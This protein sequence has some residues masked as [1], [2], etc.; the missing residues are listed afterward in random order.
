MN[1]DPLPA[2]LPA[3]A[4][5][6]DTRR[7]PKAHDVQRTVANAA[8]TWMAR[9]TSRK[10]KR[11]RSEGEEDL[12]DIHGILTIFVFQY[13][14]DD[15]GIHVIMNKQ[16]LFIYVFIYLKVYKEDHI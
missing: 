9:I 13:Y 6:S 4:S 14:R 2:C 16:Y 5:K 10:R 1:R 12:R 11:G 3:L 15:I 7:S 8:H